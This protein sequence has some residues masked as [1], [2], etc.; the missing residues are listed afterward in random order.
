M[1]LI[2]RRRLPFR[3]GDRETDEVGDPPGACEKS[4]MIEMLD[5]SEHISFRIAKRVEP[6]APLMGDDDDLARS[7]KLH[8]PPGTLLHIDGE[9]RLL[10]NSRTAHPVA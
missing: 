9:T 4:D 2:A 1:A 6:S 7:A 8:R 3:L 10:K 5:K